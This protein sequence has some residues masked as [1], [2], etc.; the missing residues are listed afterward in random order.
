MSAGA[1]TSRVPGP[2]QQ[3]QLLQVIGPDFAL[4]RGSPLPLGASLRRRGVNF[5][6][7]AGEATGVTLVLFFPECCEPLIEFPLDQRFNRTGEV[8]HCFLAGLD[9]GVQYAYRVAG[10][11]RHPDDLL[12]DPYGK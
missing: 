11:G 1:S 6:L 4:E 9:P 2:V 7:F 8:W 12:L 5:S 3:E 10:P